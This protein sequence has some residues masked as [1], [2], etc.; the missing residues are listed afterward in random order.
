MQNFVLY[1]VLGISH[2]YA[3]ILPFCLFPQERYQ[4]HSTF[5][6]NK[7]DCGLYQRTLD[8]KL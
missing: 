7:T 1:S 3:R 8:G 5:Q 4:E 6:D 2:L